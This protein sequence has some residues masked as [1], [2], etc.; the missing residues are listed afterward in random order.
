MNTF[1]QIVPVGLGLCSL[2]VDP[3]IVVEVE[4]GPHN[5]R[6]GEGGPWYRQA[7]CGS[8]S[9]LTPVPFL[10]SSLSSH[11]PLYLLLRASAACS[12]SYSLPHSA[13]LRLPFSPHPQPALVMDDCPPPSCPC[14][15]ARD[16]LGTSVSSMSNFLPVPKPAHCPPSPAPPTPFRVLGPALHASEMWS[17]C[18]L[19]VLYHSLPPLSP[20]LP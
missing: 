20:L 12:L 1:I 10:E 16:P 3:P 5:S 9:V 11:V 8:A 2:S 4:N 15:T 7:L 6:P 13:F 14:R 18:S 17:V 19:P